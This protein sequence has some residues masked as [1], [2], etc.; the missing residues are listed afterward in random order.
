[1][2]KKNKATQIVQS[3]FEVFMLQSYHIMMKQKNSIT[4]YGQNSYSW[5][6]IRT[7]ICQFVANI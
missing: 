7:T 1:M 6:T 5:K 4:K 2:E 3:K